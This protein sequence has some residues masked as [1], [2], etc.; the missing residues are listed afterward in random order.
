MGKN[1]PIIPMTREVNPNRVKILFIPLCK[2]FLVA[3]VL[4]IEHPDNKIKLLKH[5]FYD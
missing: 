4:E 3:N 5:L 2:L 1:A